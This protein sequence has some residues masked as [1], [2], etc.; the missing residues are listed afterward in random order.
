MLQAFGG[1]GRRLTILQ[2][3]AHIDWRDDVGGE[4][5]GLSSTMRRASEMAHVERIIQVGQRGIGS[6]RPADLAAARDWG[7]SFVSAAEVAREGIGRAL[8][9]IPDGAEVAVCLDVDAFDPAIMPA[10]IGRTAGA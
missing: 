4:R 1:R 8:S 9:L 3:D 10:A 7:V 2:I 5:W 6:A